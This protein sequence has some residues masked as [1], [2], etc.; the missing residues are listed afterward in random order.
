MNCLRCFHAQCVL[1]MCRINCFQTWKKRISTSQLL[2]DIKLKPIETYIDQHQMR[3]AGHVSRMPWNRLSQKI[4]TAW[5]NSKRPK[6]SQ[7]F[8]AL[9]RGVFTSKSTSLNVKK[10]VYTALILSVLLHGAEAWSLTETE[11]HRLRCFHAQRVQETCRINR[12]QTW[13]KRISTSQLLNDLKLKPIE[14]YIDQRQMR[15]AGHV[16]RMTWNRLPQKMLTAWCN[17]KRSKGS[18]QMTYG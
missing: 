4:L 5:C 15:W 10:A 17:S 3:G 9:R 2:N 8:G 11:I 14:T 18:P 7:A 12:F 6:T 1:A 13:K 16:S